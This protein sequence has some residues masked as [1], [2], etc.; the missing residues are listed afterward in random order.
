MDSVEQIRKKLRNQEFSHL[1]SLGR[2]FTVAEEWPNK[3]IEPAT[4]GIS[5]KTIFPP[6]N[7]AGMRLI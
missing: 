4:E 6:R 7:P 2:A 3:A 1:K 5:E